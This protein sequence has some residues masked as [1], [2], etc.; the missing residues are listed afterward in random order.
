MK[1]FDERHA[2][3][4]RD[5]IV[6]PHSGLVWLPGGP[7]L[8]ESY[9][10]LIRSLGW[11]DIRPELLM[12][13]TTLTRS[14]IPFPGTGYY[15]WLLEVV[16]AALFGLSVAP[17]SWLLLSDGPSGRGYVAEA[18]EMLA[19]GRVIHA[20]GLRRVDECIVSAIDPFSG[21]VQ[22]T[23]IERIRSSFSPG[24]EERDWPKRVYVSR[25]KDSKRV[26]RN[27]AEVEAAMREIGLSV[28][29]PQDLS[30]RDQIALFSGAELV[31]ATHGAGLA[32]LVWAERLSRLVEIFPA[33]Y[34]NDVYAR[35][36]RM[37]GVEYRYLVCTRDR[38]SAGIVPVE[39]VTAA[40]AD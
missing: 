34:V 30:F 28:V 25:R 24:R 2:Y 10:S 33:E 6:S 21:F 38:R 23:E 5:V 31:V 15:H 16:P 40:V 12:P 18:A 26:V 37:A 39:A 9:G 1:A 7:V 36:S 29:F 3:R 32:N 20:N 4:L 8:E 22:A 13:A 17:D 19:P 27:E 35:L 11:G 14:V